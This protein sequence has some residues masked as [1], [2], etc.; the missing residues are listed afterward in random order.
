MK[1]FVD[2][3]NEAINLDPSNPSE[4]FQSLY[5]QVSWIEDELERFT[6]D[7]FSVFKDLLHSFSF[8]TDDPIIYDGHPVI[9]VDSDGGYE[10]AGEIVWYVFR[11]NDAYVKVEGWY[12]SW[13]GSCF[14][15]AYEVE[16][17]QEFVT[18]YRKKEL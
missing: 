6:V 14:T 12:D 16:P 7:E 9:F 10:G 1:S 13:A 18:K 2:L 17:Y 3:M 15:N 5:S 8:R 4:D 11:H